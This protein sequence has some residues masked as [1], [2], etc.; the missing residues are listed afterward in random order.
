MDTLVTTE[1]TVV[2]LVTLAVVVSVSVSTSPLVDVEIGPVGNRSAL[3]GAHPRTESLHGNLS[4]RV[5]RL[6]AESR[7]SIASSP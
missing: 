4:Y 1:K 2:L 5:K 7:C 3:P 6:D